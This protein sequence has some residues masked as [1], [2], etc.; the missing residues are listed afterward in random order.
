MIHVFRRIN[1]VRVDLLR[2]SLAATDAGKSGDDPSVY[3]PACQQVHYHR[4]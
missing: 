3:R 1:R 4:R 2:L